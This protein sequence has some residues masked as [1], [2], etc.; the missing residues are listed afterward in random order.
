VV[1]LYVWVKQLLKFNCLKMDVNKIAFPSETLEGVIDQAVFVLSRANADNPAGTFNTQSGNSNFGA[2]Q[3]RFEVRGYEVTDGSFLSGNEVNSDELARLSNDAGQKEGLYYA[4]TDLVT[5]AS[6]NSYSLL[7]QSSGKTKVLQGNLTLS[8]VGT[9]HAA[10]IITVA[11]DTTY[12]GSDTGSWLYFRITDDV[13]GEVRAKVVDG[14]T[15][16]CTSLSGAHTTWK[17]EVVT[18]SNFGNVGTLTIDNEATWPIA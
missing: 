4:E 7:K 1:L 2:V 12:A 13:G 5:F 11:D 18:I 10:G 6:A 8:L 17:I 3:P 14:G 9:D 15:I 16:D